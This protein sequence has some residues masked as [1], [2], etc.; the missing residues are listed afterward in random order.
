MTILE[1]MAA[2]KPV[3][4]TRVGAIPKVI[5]DGENG[6]LVNPRDT[7]GLRNVIA[8][9]LADPD[10]CRR[11]GEKAHDWVRRN[12]TSAAMA[13]KYR[14]LYEG[15]LARPELAIV[16]EQNMGAHLHD[17]SLSEDRLRDDRSNVDARGA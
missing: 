15:I 12:Y 14:E 17:A 3:V 7:D 6:L 10:R 4:A 13:Q 11:M 9:L 8:S 2:S 1:A 5:S 16:P